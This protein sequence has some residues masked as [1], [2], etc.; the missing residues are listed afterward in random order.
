MFWLRSPTWSLISSFHI[1]SFHHKILLVKYIISRFMSKIPCRTITTLFMTTHSSSWTWWGRRGESRSGRRKRPRKLQKRHGCKQGLTPGQIGCFRDRQTPEYVM[2][3]ILLTCLCEAWQI[4]T[5][6]CIID[7]ASPHSLKWAGARPN[8]TPQSEGSG[9]VQCLQ[10]DLF[11]AVF[12]QFSYKT[13][14]MNRSSF[15]KDRQH[16]S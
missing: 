12:L 15:D 7:W 1:S 3:Q 5:L 10:I 13:F 6:Y 4:L 9:F 11:L 8:K 16:S 2:K 14:L